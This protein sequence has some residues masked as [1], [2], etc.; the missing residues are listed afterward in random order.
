MPFIVLDIETLGAL[1]GAPAASRYL[2]GLVGL[3]SARVA[4]AM[5]TL[6]AMLLGFVLKRRI[7]QDGWQRG[8]AY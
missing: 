4:V 7:T 5:L 8:I 3:S 1:A 6:A 2:S